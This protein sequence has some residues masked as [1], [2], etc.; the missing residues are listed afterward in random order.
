LTVLSL[1]PISLSLCLPLD[2]YIE[3]RKS[4]LYDHSFSP[5]PMHNDIKLSREYLKQM[6]TLGFPNIQREFPDKFVKFLSTTKQLESKGL[7]QLL[8]RAGG[9]CK[10]GRK[11]VL[12]SLP[13]IGSSASV[14]LMKDLLMGKARSKELTPEIKEAWL[15]SMFYL[16]RPDVKIIETMFS[17][18]QYYET[19]SNPMYILIPSSLVHTYC[20]NHGDCRES[21]VISNIVKYLEG[22]VTDNL[23][24]DLSDKKTYQKLIV[25]MKGLGNIGMLS[26]PL[27]TELKETIIDES[28]S[29]D[30][31]LQVIQMFR[32]TNCDATRDYFVDIYQ[33]ATQSVEVRI[34][35]Y[36]QL[37]RCPTY[38]TIKD[39]KSFLQKERVNQV[40][41]FVWSHL[42]NLAKTSSPQKI[43]VQALLGEQCVLIECVNNC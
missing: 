37:M 19:E 28:F 29:D 2:I 24:K 4:L 12:E 5:K 36:L 6:C 10:N 13:Y 3:V 23:S 40:G 27:E 34:A 8:A 41:S 32:K 42:K 30:I 26:K 15:I 43:E 1:S 35:S 31:K 17:L 33:N 22:V 25:A 20:R 14:E 18:I 21:V 7:T 11:H 9:M 38:L 39:I 16:P